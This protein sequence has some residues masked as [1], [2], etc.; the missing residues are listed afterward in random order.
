MEEK[1]FSP[2]RFIP[3]INQGK[4]PYC[5]SVYIEGA[6]IL[7]DPACLS[8]SASPDPRNCFFP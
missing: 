4:Y 6:K 7:I 2:I 1:K 3:G 5:H 8:F